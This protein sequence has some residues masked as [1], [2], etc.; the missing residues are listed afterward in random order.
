MENLSE[1]PGL[2]LLAVLDAL[3]KADP[4]PPGFNASISIGVRSEEGDTWW[5][6]V[7]TETIE[8]SIGNEPLP[9]ADATLL[10]GVAEAE[11]ML[12]HGRMSGGTALVVMSGSRWAVE[13]LFS[14]YIT[15]ENPMAARTQRS[16]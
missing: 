2:R 9:E 5:R 8:T 13:K 14:R 1:T 12:R 11:A 10:L 7:I 6:A 15:R 4:E 16:R 3:V